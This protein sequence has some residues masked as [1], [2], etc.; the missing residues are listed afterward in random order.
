MLKNFSIKKFSKYLLIGSSALVLLFTVQTSAF[1]NIQ[2]VN[3][4]DCTPGTSVNTCHTLTGA[5]HTYCVWNASGNTESSC[6]VESC[7][8]GGTPPDCGGSPNQPPTNDTLPCMTNPGLCGENT[9]YCENTSGGGSATIFKHAGACHPENGGHDANGCIFLFDNVRS[10]TGPN[11]QDNNVSIPPSSTQMVN[12]CGK[13]LSQDQLNS[14]LRGANYPGPWDLGSATAAYQR[15]ACPSGG[16]PPPPAAVCVSNGSCSASPACGTTAN[17]VD[18]CGLPCQRTGSACV[19]ACTPNGSCSAQTPTAC[20]QSFTGVDN[21][22]NT[23]TKQSSA[24]PIIVTATGGSASAT[25]GSSVVT[26]NNPA[27]VIAAPATFANVGVGTTVA[28]YTVTTLPKTGLPIFAWSA[29]AFLPAGFRMRRF[30]KVKKDL[31]NHPSY[32]FDMRQYKSDG[33]TQ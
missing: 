13:T 3:A 2:E 27:P 26:I 1:Q 15:A 12:V 5:G 6:K 25:G 22:G 16:T 20:G 11:C 7:F 28:G 14:E 21:C 10:F 29:L 30:S 31:E 9:Q 4:L 23:C 19:I 8:N 33:L 32:I 17:G 24:C 18:N